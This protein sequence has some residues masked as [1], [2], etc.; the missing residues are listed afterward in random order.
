MTNFRNRTYRILVTYACIRKFRTE[1]SCSLLKHWP[2]AW[3]SARLDAENWPVDIRWN[4]EDTDY[5]LRYE[6]ETGI[7][8]EVVLYNCQIPARAVL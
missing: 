2:T 8:C 3:S 4:V 1:I 5:L 6:V 7:Y